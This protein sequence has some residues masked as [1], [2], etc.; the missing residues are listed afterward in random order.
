MKVH[1]SQ[2]NIFFIWTGLV[3]IQTHDLGHKEK[4][5]KRPLQQV[6]KNENGKID[7]LEKF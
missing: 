5:W 4:N 6:H 2:N 1:L 7:S 3:E